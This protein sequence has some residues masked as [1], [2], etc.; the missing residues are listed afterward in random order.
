MSTIKLSELRGYTPPPQP[1][2]EYGDC[3]LPSP[4]MIWVFRSEID[5]LHIPLCTIH[6]RLLDPSW[7]PDL[8]SADDLERLEM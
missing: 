7:G 1:P 4:F 2:C 3:N 6:S 8:Y 5:P